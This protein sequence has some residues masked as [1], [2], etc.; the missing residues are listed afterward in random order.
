MPLSRLSSM[1]RSFVV[2]FQSDANVS[3]RRLAG[4]VEHVRTGDV[5]HFK[6]LDELLRFVEDRMEADREEPCCRSSTEECPQ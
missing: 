6:S 5:T 1:V 2:Q 4:R 3:E